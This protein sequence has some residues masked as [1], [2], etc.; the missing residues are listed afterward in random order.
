LGNTHV[1]PWK[2]ASPSLPGPPSPLTSALR[3]D[4][5]VNVAVR[6][7]GGRWSGRGRRRVRTPG[8]DQMRPV[9]RER[10]VVAGGGPAKVAVSCVRPVAAGDDPVEV[11]V[12]HKRPVAAGGDSV[13]VAVSCERLVVAG[14]VPVTPGAT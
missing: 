1:S 8:G 13:E 12:R 2:Y 6:C 5:S 3:S 7:G 11:A 14:G 10:P 4:A 9:R